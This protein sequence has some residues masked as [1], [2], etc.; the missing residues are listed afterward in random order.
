MKRRAF[1]ALAVAV[2]AA[3]PA[4]G[5]QP[6]PPRRIGLL[7]P[8]TAAATTNLVAAFEEGLR[9][10]GY[11]KGRD[12]VIEYRYTDDRPERIP[13]LAA[14]LAQARV[15]AIVT[16]TDA[17]VRTVMRHTAQIPIVMVNTS[18][19]G[20]SGLVKELAK[21]GGRVTGLTNLS[22]EIGGKRIELLK[23]AVPE[24]LRVVYLWNPDL[25]AAAQAYREIEAA[26]RLLRIE[27]R[28]AEVRRAEDVGIAFA[29]LATGPG[30]GLIVQAPNPLL[31]SL[32]KQIAELANKRRIPS[33]F[34][35]HEYVEDCPVC[36]RANAIRVEVDADG[37][38][39][40]W[41]ELE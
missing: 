9:E 11:L 18:D 27:I 30:T 33:M 26:V 36:C 7:M 3:A 2:L 38:V 5:Q 31:Y 21:P 32:R 22:P 8:S 1:I 40:A 14:D 24:M 28:S 37:E 4:R 6:A 12:V 10:H 25:A 41:A 35:R 39:S 17:V 19:P 34:N 20:G 13:E 29:A 16:T 23:E 15:A